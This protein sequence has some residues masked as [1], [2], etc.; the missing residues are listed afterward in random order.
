M[1]IHLALSGKAQQASSEIEVESLCK[2]SSV[3]TLLAKLDKLLLDESKGQFK[4]LQESY[5]L[6]RNNENKMASVI[7]LDFVSTKKM[8]SIVFACNL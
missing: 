3:G 6:K 7:K 8:R 1:A 4:A 5:N 2:D